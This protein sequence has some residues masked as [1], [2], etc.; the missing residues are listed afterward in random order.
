VVQA[1]LAPAGHQ[2]EFVN[3]GGAA[4][5]AVAREAYDI[6]LMDMHMPGMD[7]L[8]ATR[9]IRT[10]PPPKG[11]IPILGVTASTLPE[12]VAVCYK[13]GVDGHLAKPIDRGS[14]LGAMAELVA[15]Q[16]WRTAPPGPPRDEPPLLNEASLRRALAELDAMAGPALQDMVQEIVRGCDVLAEPQIVRDVAR[17][18]QAAHLVMEPARSLGCERLVVGID[19][20][21][22]AIRAGQDVESHLRAL[23]A[24]REATLPLLEQAAISV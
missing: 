8:E 2:V 19:R 13:A 4:V 18:R 10:L 12:E 24:L 17:M 6:V 1:L 22:R 7:G 5:S 20:L 21:Q 9:R 11:A 23:P 15:G 3:S 14:L 16:S